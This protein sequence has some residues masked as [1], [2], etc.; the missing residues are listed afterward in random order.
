MAFYA[1]GLLYLGSVLAPTAKQL[2]QSLWGLVSAAATALLVAQIVVQSI[3]K[4]G[5]AGWATDDHTKRVLQL[6]GLNRAESVARLVLVRCQQICVHLFLSCLQ[7]AAVMAALDAT[8]T[9]S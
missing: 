2:K 6:F 4:A 1:W 9:Y 5:N 3:Y 8:S 7:S